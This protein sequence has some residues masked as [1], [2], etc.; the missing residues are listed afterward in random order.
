MQD[1]ITADQ[2]YQ[3]WMA[4][5]ASSGTCGA[6]PASDPS[7]AAGQQASVPATAAKKAFLNIWNPMAPSYG[8]K[9]YSSTDF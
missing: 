1:S 8:Q 5:F 2:D 4:G 6:N 7:Y 3:D 9:T